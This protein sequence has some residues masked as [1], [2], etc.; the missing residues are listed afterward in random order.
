MAIFLTD[1]R[2]LQHLLIAKNGL[3]LKPTSCEISENLSNN[4]DRALKSSIHDFL[5]SYERELT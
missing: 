5:K 1:R 4:L 3:K 2:D